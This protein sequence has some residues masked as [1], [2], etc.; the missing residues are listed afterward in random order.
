LAENIVNDIQSKGGIITLDDLANYKV[1]RRKVLES[2]VGDFTLHAMS[3]PTGGPIVSHIINILK[4]MH[5]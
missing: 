2:D 1:I 4:G 3:S 5:V